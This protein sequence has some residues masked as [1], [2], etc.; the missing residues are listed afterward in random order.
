MTTEQECCRAIADMLVAH[1]INDVVASPGSRNAPLLEAV[2]LTPELKTTVVA[3]ER[4]AA[5]VALGMASIAQR[6]VT[7]VCTS[8]TALLNYSPALAEAYYRRIKLIVLTADRPH[9]A[10]CRN[11]P[12]TM[13]QSGIYDSFVKKSFNLDCRDSFHF[14][15]TLLNDALTAVTMDPPG[16][17]HINLEIPDP[18]IMPTQQTEAVE[19][20]APRTIR[21]AQRSGLITKQTMTD[22]SRRLQSA[23]K[24][25]IVAGCCQPDQVLSKAIGRLGRFGNFVIMADSLSNLHGDGVIDFTDSALSEMGRRFTDDLRPDII[26][27]F[28]GAPLSAHLAECVKHDNIEHWHVGI[29]DT[30][31]D[32]FGTMSM[33]IDTDAASFF[34]QLVSVMRRP[35][36]TS[37]YV[38]RWMELSRR[39]IMSTRAFLAQA[40]WSDMKA[41]QQILTR[42]PHNYNVQL[43]NGMAVRYG[44]LLPSRFHRVDCN[45]GVSGIDGSTSTAIGAS[46]KYDRGTLLITG[47]MSAAYDLNALTL[48]CIPPRL[49]IAVINNHGGG[50][51]KYIKGTRDFD[52]IDRFMMPRINVSFPEIARASGFITYEANNED[53]LIDACGRMFRNQDQGPILTVI[54]TDADVSARMMRQYIRR[55]DTQ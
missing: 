32:S 46:M 43:S 51:F 4:S 39:A 29:A 7:L 30:C 16:P 5:F 37:D 41:V 12:Q 2:A 47:D 18:S 50:I 23:A 9:E 28:G 17:V 36:N 27:T 1:G 40:E 55:S 53:E 25:M 19:R 11:L 3:D 6:P 21:I 45:R 48:D 49:R 24:I 34:A 13:V 52:S 54:N 35:E 42:T 33:R 44:Q 31:L 26:I 8:G 38:Q 14:R 15:D 20:T 10:I 22:L